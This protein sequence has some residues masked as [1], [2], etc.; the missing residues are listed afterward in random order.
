MKA[1]NPKQFSILMIIAVIIV[2]LFTLPSTIDKRKR[3]NA[4]NRDGGILVRIGELSGES[5]EKCL[6]KELYNSEL[7]IWKG[8][9]QDP[10]KNPNNTNEIKIPPKDNIYLQE[11]LNGSDKKRH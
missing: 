4:C 2:L 7:R 6:A 5:V 9:G 3:I 11:W 8:L 10:L 1:L